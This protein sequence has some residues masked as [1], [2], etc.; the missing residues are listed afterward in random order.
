VKPPRILCP[1]FNVAHWY[2]WQAFRASL[3][4]NALAE[5]IAR[6]EFLA[7]RAAQGFGVGAADLFDWLI[8]AESKRLLLRASD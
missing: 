6:S 7:W 1:S 4:P 2:A 5:S 8:V 3:E